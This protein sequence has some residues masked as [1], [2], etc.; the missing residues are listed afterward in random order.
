VITGGG[1]DARG[2]L[3]GFQE[4]RGGASEAHRR[5]G[6]RDGSAASRR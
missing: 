5:R 4:V 1:A 6:P 3:G 2:R